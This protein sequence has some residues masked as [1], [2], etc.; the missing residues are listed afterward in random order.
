MHI[1]PLQD[2]YRTYTHWT[3]PGAGP[4]LSRSPGPGP[5]HEAVRRLMNSFKVDGL[6][7]APTR[8]L[9]ILF[10]DLEIKGNL[11]KQPLG[12]ED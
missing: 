4:R 7:R 8:Q 5:G 1:R 11:F 3:G 10:P 12:Y 2:F 9:E 6:P